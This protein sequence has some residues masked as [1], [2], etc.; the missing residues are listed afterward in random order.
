MALCDRLR[1]KGYRGLLPHQEDQRLEKDRGFA[2]DFV[3]WNYDQVEVAE[4][5]D[6]K[7]IQDAL[8][9]MDK[10]ADTLYVLKANSDEAPTIVPAAND[11]AVNRILIED[12]LERFKKWYEKEGFSLEEKIPDI[13]EFTPEAYG[14]D[15]ELISVSVDIEHKHLGSRGGQIEG[16][17]LSLVQWQ[18]LDSPVF[19]YFLEPLA[20]Q[21]LRPNEFTICDMSVYWSPSREKFFFGEFCPNR[22]GYDCLFAEIA[23]TGGVQEWVER[24]RSSE[25]FGTD[26]EFGTAVRIFNKQKGDKG[27]AWKE[28]ILGSPADPNAFMWDIKEENGKIYTA[29]YDTNTYVVAGAGNTVAS[30]IDDVYKNDER[31]IF[32]S[33][34]SLEK[35]DWYDTEYP[36]NILHRYEIL[37]KLEL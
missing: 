29:G 32:D 7:T 4:Y 16:C 22:P 30:A 18:E 34:F 11:P 33:G 35:H 14:Y 28:L 15:G 3:A 6:F 21:M 5:E 1:K 2:K 27:R 19:E 24:I 12:S 25:N 10:H 31:I 36:E 8:R 23:S 26:K 17:C 13:I 20:A 9:Y 37:K